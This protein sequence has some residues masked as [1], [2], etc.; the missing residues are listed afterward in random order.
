M[1]RTRDILF[2][3]R[4]LTIVEL[5]YSHN[6]FGWGRGHRSG[7][8][9]LCFAWCVAVRVD[10]RRVDNYNLKEGSCYRFAI[11]TA[12]GNNGRNV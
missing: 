8:C 1:C 6:T 4:A 5:S 9:G 7:A 12:G 11:N 10:R 3:W 2:A